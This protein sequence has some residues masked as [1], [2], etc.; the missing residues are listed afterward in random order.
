V[1]QSAG[2]GFAVPINVAK[3][4]LPQLKEKGILPPHLRFQAG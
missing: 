1:P 4:I 2:V 3:E